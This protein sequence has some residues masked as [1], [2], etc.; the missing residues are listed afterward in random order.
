MCF[1]PSDSCNV[2]ENQRMSYWG[3][4]M[5]IYTDAL[6]R[7]QGLVPS[8][9]STQ[10]HPTVP[11]QNYNLAN[12]GQEAVMNN[13]A[14]KALDVE[15]Q[16]L[17][18]MQ[19]GSYHEKYHMEMVG[20][21]NKMVN[22]HKE[23]SPESKKASQETLYGKDIS[24]EENFTF[25]IEENANLIGG[26]FY[27]QQKVTWMPRIHPANPNPTADKFGNVNNFNNYWS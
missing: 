6:A 7:N 16:L 10:V 14:A 25:C 20:S 19:A 3:Q 1:S 8:V 22:L 18:D 21:L 9:Q 12:L 11:F 26:Q 15:N 23:V 17:G 5:S 2:L 13:N 27:E 24:G 4:G